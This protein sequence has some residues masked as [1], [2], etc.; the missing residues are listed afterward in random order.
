MTGREGTMNDNVGTTTNDSAGTTNNNMGTTNNNAGTTNNNAG[1]R[2]NNVGMRQTGDTTNDE[3]DNNEYR[4]TTYDAPLS[5]Q[6]Q[7][8]GVFLF[9]FFLHSFV[10]WSLLPFFFLL[11]T[12]HRC[13]N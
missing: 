10:I 11:A 1:M 8:R 13:D 2:N 6:T 3:A 4:G 7:D 9:F 5:L 12:S